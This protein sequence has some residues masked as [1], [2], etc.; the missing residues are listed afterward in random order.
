M[1]LT[2]PAFEQVG[3]IIWIVAGAEKASMVDRLLA[4]DPTIPAGRVP[5]NRAVLVTN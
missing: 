2:F 1:T 3:S 5:Q 4:A